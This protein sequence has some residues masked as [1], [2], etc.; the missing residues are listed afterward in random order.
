MIEGLL[1]LR[2]SIPGNA[3]TV[4]AKAV[5]DLEFRLVQF[6]EWIHALSR[7]WREEI[8]STLHHH[9]MDSWFRGKFPIGGFP[10]MLAPSLVSK[11]AASE[12]STLLGSQGGFEVRVFSQDQAS[13]AIAMVMSQCEEL[14][15]DFLC[16]AGAGVAYWTTM[17]DFE[18]EANEEPGEKYQS[19]WNANYPQLYEPHP[20]PAARFTLLPQVFITILAD[21]MTGVERRSS[22]IDQMWKDAGDRLKPKLAF[23]EN[24]MLEYRNELAPSEVQTIN[25]PLQYLRAF[26]SSAFECFWHMMTDWMHKGHPLGLL[27]WWFFSSQYHQLIADL[28]QEFASRI[29]SPTNLGWDHV[30]GAAAARLCCDRMPCGE[31][32]NELQERATSFLEQSWRQ[33]YIQLQFDLG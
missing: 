15:V 6:H 20:I 29:P 10:N 14:F 19:T 12:G 16:S 26:Y 33:S 31:R 3:I 2:L 17:W 11:D 32:V 4:P 23:D 28:T 18:I 22:L 27:R 30:A 1:Q 8:Y 5:T 25:M 13:I 21:V 9:L 7:E 24:A